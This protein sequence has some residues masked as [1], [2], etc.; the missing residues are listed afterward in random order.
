VIDQRPTPE[1]AAAHRDL[2]HKLLA[3]IPEDDRLL[4]LWREVEGCSITTLAE[5]TGMNENTIK[6][7]LFRAR[8]KLVELAGRLAARPPAS[9]TECRP[10]G[11]DQDRL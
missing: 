6:V 5:M 7:R 2:L 11:L 1:R 4:L 3:L 10:V 9:G 8:R